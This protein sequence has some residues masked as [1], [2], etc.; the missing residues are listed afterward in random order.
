MMMVVVQ[1]RSGEPVGDA[2]TTRALYRAF[3]A[4]NQALYSEQFL[5]RW[6][7]SMSGRC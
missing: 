5:V 4:F 7:L 2:A 1:V 3:A 6:R